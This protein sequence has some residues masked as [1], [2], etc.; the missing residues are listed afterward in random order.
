LID[1][2]VEMADLLEYDAVVVDLVVIH[3]FKMVVVAVHCCESR[4]ESS[5]LLVYLYG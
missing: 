5:V 1:Y 2:R 4:N 3:A